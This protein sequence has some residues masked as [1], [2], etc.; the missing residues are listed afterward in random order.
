MR[1]FQITYFGSFGSGREYSSSASMQVAHPERGAVEKVP[2]VIDDAIAIRSV[3]YLSLSFDHRLIDGALGD[4]F[5]IKIK[6]VLEDWTERSSVSQDRPLLSSVAL[7]LDAHRLVNRL[8]FA[9]LRL[10]GMHIRLTLVPG[11]FGTQL[12]VALPTGVV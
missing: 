8:P 10:G 9:L 5:V 4:Q 6:Q 1:R 11:D 12:G 3:M 7:V 2:V